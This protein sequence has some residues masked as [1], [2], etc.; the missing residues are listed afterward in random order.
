MITT[1]YRVEFPPDVAVRDSELYDGALD[2]SYPLNRTAK[3]YLDLL[4]AG[5][6][7]PGVVDTVSTQFAIPRSDAERDLLGLVG[8]LNDAQLV[9]VSPRR[10]IDR[11]KRFFWVSSYVITTRTFPPMLVKRGRVANGDPISVAASVVVALFRHALPVLIVAALFIVM[12]GTLKGPETTYPLAVVLV[13]TF[14]AL[15]FHEVG[16]AMAVHM[17]GGRSYLMMTGLK[18]AVAHNFGASP[19]VHASGPLLAGLVGL[20]VVLVAYVAESELMAFASLPFVIHL[21]SLTFLSRDGRLL[22]ESLTK[23]KERRLQ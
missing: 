5:T 8:Q 7:V 20:V 15:L 19:V 9:N 18:V 12:L 4:H 21:S 3:R 23:T 11:L 6:P 22:V 10:L 16:H 1:A 17:V 2:E 14:A 13:G